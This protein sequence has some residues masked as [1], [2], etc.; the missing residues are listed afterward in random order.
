[1][2]CSCTPRRPTTR[3]TAQVLVVADQCPTDRADDLNRRAVG[4][5]EADRVQCRRRDRSSSTSARAE[6]DRH[7]RMGG[8]QWRDFG[9]G[10]WPGVADVDDRYFGTMPSN[11]LGVR[12]RTE[13]AQRASELLAA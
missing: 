3:L 13:A 2:T 10:E 1:M 6:H 8:P 11:K 7:R 9:R 12:N 5:E 4:P